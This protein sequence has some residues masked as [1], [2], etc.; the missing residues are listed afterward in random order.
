VSR[1]HE[2]LIRHEGIRLKPYRDARHKLTIGVGRNLD[3]VGV[4]RAEAL[5]LLNNDIARVRREV[6]GA[7]S[8]FPGLNPVRK[9]V[10][11]DMVFNLGLT[12]FR[13]FKKAIAAIKAKDWEKAARE[14]LNSQWAKQVGRRARELAA[15]MNRGKYEVDSNRLSA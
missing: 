5:M 14:M 9:D 11:L 1:L 12:R 2:M 15:M 8:W 4:T 13:R 10:V 3:D 6:V 7:F